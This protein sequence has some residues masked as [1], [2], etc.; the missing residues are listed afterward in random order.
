MIKRAR[1]AMRI[2]VRSCGQPSLAATVRPAA[3]TSTSALSS[4]SLSTS[5]M[6]A[7]LKWV[8]EGGQVNLF[9]EENAVGRAMG[10][11]PL[12]ST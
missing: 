6:A 8:Q 5:Y 11:G 10:M 2:A 12:S 4:G 7:S 3:R 9:D 1:S